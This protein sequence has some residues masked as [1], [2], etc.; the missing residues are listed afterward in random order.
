MCLHPALAIPGGINGG[1]VPRVSMNKYYPK[2][3]LDRNLHGTS[4]WPH[5]GGSPPGG[6]AEKQMPPANSPNDTVST[7]TDIEAS[8]YYTSLLSWSI[9]Y[10]VK[11]KLLKSLSL[12]PSLL[13]N[14]NGYP[15]QKLIW[16]TSSSWAAYHIVQ[17]SQ[18]VFVD[19]K[20]LL[21]YAVRGLRG[22]IIILW[23]SVFL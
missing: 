7:P 6:F 15:W 1:N 22:L 8:L 14:A 20:Y 4:S 16:V 19:T 23:E 12:M 2:P 13:Q 11:R 5:L 9:E 3:S 10:N 17:Q 18:L 21:L